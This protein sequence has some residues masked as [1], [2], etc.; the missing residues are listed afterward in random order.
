MC[1]CLCVCVCVCVGV[2]VGCVLVCVLCLRMDVRGCARAYV[3]V[4]SQVYYEHSPGPSIRRVHCRSFLGLVDLYVRLYISD[5]KHGC[6]GVI[7]WICVIC[8]QQ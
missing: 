5:L 1:V 6:P 3:S 2:C 7:S 4:R 8:R